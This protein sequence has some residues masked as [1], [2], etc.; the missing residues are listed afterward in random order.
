MTFQPSRPL[1]AK[2]LEFFDVTGNDN[3]KDFGID[4][5]GNAI[6][7]HAESGTYL[8]W[9]ADEKTN[10]SIHQQSASFGMPVGMSEA[11]LIL[12]LKEGNWYGIPLDA[13]WTLRSARLFARNQGFP[14]QSP[15]GVLVQKSLVQQIN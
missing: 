9:V 14:G 2:A 3:I 13:L 1:G 5:L 11:A 8:A 15:L 7:K 10:D 12:C 6:Y 4:K